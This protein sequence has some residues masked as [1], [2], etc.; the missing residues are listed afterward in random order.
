M[1]N[2]LLPI[3]RTLHVP[4]LLTAYGIFF[5]AFLVG[6]VYLWEERQMKSKHPNTLTFRLPSLEELDNLIAKLISA[7]FPLLTLGLL[8]GGIWAQHAWGRFWGW[9][10]KETWTLITC[11]VYASYLSARA[12]IGWRGR[13]S[14]YL[15]LA[16]FAVVLFTYMGVSYFSPLHGF[17]YGKVQ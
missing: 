7:A 17:F 9:D 16:G 15:S 1:D 12:F 3:A 5:A 8:L 13:K 10:P 4:L 11:L 14:T 6:I 2:Y